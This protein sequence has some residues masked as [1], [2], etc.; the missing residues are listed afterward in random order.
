M[1]EG[2]G[3]GWRIDTAWEEVVVVIG[4]VAVLEM[5]WFYFQSVS[6]MDYQSNYFWPLVGSFQLFSP[7]N[8]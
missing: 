5:C 3:A 2:W 8:V 1:W 4:E 7:G 6:N